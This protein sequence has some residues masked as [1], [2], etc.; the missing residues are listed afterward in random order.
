MTGTVSTLAVPSHVP[1]ERVFDFDYHN[2]SR[3]ARDVHDGLMSLREDAPDVF[4]TPHHGGHWIVTDSALISM[5]LKT[6]ASFSSTQL[7]I[8]PRDNAPRMIPES[9]DPPEHLLY[10]RLMMEYFEKSRIGH[11]QERIDYWTGTLISKIK[12]NG[13][14]EMVEELTSRLPVYVFMEFVGFPMDRFSDFR[15]LVDGMFRQF[16]PVKRQEF[17]MKI[18]G[19]LQEL[20][21]ARMAAP[22]DD[23]LSKLIAADFKGRKLTFEELMSIAF[24]MFLA[25]LDTVTNAMTFGLKHLVNDPALRHRVRKNPSELPALVE[26]LLR[27]YTFPTLPRQVTKDLELGGAQ[28]KK[29]EMVLCLIALVGLDESLNPDALQVDLDREKRTH[30]AFGYGG[31]TCLGR[32]LAKME[33]EALYAQWLQDIPDFE[34]D[35]SKTPDRP[36]GGAVMGMPNLYLKW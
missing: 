9:L 1:D 24:L 7:Q 2:D 13:R 21:S 26:E 28:L 22:K 23:I 16:D 34:I 11:L 30:F 36:R 6:P 10:R 15:A 35:P 29:G 33:L 18:M 17:A 32:H 31:H 27:R 4:W 20:I 8:P 5:V 19:E 14:A 25:G 12:P 3:M